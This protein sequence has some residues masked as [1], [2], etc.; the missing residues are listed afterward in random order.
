MKKSSHFRMPKPHRPA[1]PVVPALEWLGDVSG[2]SARA[3]VLG[4]R[5][6][7]IE[8][9]HGILDFTA[10]QVRLDTARGPLCVHG[11]ELALQ[12]V[13]PGSLIVCGCICRLELPDEGAES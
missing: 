1:Q 12:E 4:S 9:H 7:L 11:R 2:R 10:E 13:R 5:R 3:T 8:N 6:I